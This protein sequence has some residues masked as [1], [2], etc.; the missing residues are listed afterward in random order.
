[1]ACGDTDDRRTE[2]SLVS[3]GLLRDVSVVIWSGALP[4]LTSGVDSRRSQ[5]GRRLWDMSQLTF[6]DGVCQVETC[7]V[8]AKTRPPCFTP[9]LYS[10]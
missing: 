5:V 9:R 3:N 8:W 2:R 10:T 7:T 4:S 1:M 6:R